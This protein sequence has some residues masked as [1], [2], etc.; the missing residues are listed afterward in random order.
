MVIILTLELTLALRTADMTSIIEMLA[1]ILVANA[2]QLFVWHHVTKIDPEHQRRIE[3]RR[4]KRR[5]QLKKRQKQLDQKQ[6]QTKEEQ[7]GKG[8]NRKTSNKKKN[9]I[10]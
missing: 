10:G 2:Y 9:Q 6:K 7:S 1:P 5:E 3:K 8:K 4:E